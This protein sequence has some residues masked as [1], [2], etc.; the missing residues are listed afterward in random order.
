MKNVLLKNGVLLRSVLDSVTVDMSDTRTRYIDS[1][2]V[3]LFRILMQGNEV[4][5]ENF[6]HMTRFCLE[7]N[8]ELF[9]IQFSV[10]CWNF[11]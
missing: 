10:N 6:V 11:Q 3:K 8:Y 1:K 5:S 2:P 4:V 7:R 9:C